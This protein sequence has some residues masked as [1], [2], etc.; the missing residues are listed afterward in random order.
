[1]NRLEQLDIRGAKDLFKQLY[2]KVRAW[3]GEFTSIDHSS[4]LSALSLDLRRRI[5]KVVFDSY[6]N[7]PLILNNETLLGYVIEGLVGYSIAEALHRKGV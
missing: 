3:T 6:N 2:T 5:E 7:L 1:L 4:L